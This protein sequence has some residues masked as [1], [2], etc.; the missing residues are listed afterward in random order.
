MR[1][2]RPG[3]YLRF[4]LGLRSANLGLT[5][6]N[7]PIHLGPIFGDFRLVSDETHLSGASLSGNGRFS[8]KETVFWVSC[9][10]GAF[11]EAPGRKKKTIQNVL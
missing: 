3:G 4:T 6:G 8:N 9:P 5:F 10:E 1:L 2:W 7:V 11:W